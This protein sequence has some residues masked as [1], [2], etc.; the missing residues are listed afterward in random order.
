MKLQERQRAQ[1]L[2]EQLTASAAKTDEDVD[3]LQKQKSSLLKKRSRESD[4][5]VQGVL[6]R[7]VVDTL[8]K[9]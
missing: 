6:K 7:F 9:H 2:L 4:K 3:R 1:N 8:K 5:V